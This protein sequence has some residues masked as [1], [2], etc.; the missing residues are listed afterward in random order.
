M[1]W[2]Q[3]RRKMYDSFFLPVNETADLLS[4]SSRQ[5]GRTG[6]LPPFTKTQSSV[7]HVAQPQSFHVTPFQRTKASK[8]NLLLRKH[9]F[10]CSVSNRSIRKHIKIS[11]RERGDGRETRTQDVH[12]HISSI[13]FY[14]VPWSKTMDVQ[15]LGKKVDNKER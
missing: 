15:N 10:Y 6:F 1:T 2:S 8:L 12:T 13:I 4:I 9:R 5:A 3:T 14:G 7:N 11:D